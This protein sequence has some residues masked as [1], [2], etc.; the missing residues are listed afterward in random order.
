[1]RPFYIILPKI[2]TEELGG[3][4]VCWNIKK[5]EA[6]WARYIRVMMRFVT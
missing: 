5:E 4:M 6:G 2:C 3:K 1:M